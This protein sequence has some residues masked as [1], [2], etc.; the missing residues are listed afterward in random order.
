MENRKIAEEIIRQLQLFSLSGAYGVLLGIWYEFFRILRKQFWIRSKNES[1][2]RRK[3]MVWELA[4]RDRS[5][6]KGRFCVQ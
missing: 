4:F 6:I 5:M 1:W 2:I 3:S